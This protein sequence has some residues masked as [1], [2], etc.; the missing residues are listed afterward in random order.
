MTFFKCI[1]NLGLN[2]SNFSFII[3]SHFM[4]WVLLQYVHFLKI[5]TVILVCLLFLGNLLMSFSPTIASEVIKLGFVLSVA[6]S[7]PLV[8]FP[9][10][11]SL[12]SLL[13]RRVIYFFYALLKFLV[14][15]LLFRILITTMYWISW[16][17]YLWNFGIWFWFYKLMNNIGLLLIRC[18][19]YFFIY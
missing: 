18:L 2:Y 10:R 13:F 17:T 15:K 4:H 5:N 9:C 14:I 6:V 7:F 12:H 1:T 8:I 19:W 11:A 16:S 3:L